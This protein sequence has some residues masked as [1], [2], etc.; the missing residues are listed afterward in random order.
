[1]CGR[2]QRDCDEKIP[3]W[4]AAGSFAGQARDPQ[5]ANRRP[6]ASCHDWGSAAARS[7]CLTRL[8]QFDKLGHGLHFLK[9]WIVQGLLAGPACGDGFTERWHRFFELS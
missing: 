2:S 8:H 6:T 5:F 3:G 4:I 7:L 1:M 9:F